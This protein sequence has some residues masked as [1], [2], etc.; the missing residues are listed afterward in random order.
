VILFLRVA[1]IAWAAWDRKY[2]ILTWMVIPYLVEPRSA[3]A[4]SYYAFCVLITLG[5]TGALLNLVLLIKKHLGP[6]DPKSKEEVKNRVG[7]KDANLPH[8]HEMHWMNLTILTLLFYLFLDSL[9][10][11]FPLINT[12]LQKDSLEAMEWAQANTPV[13]SSF[14]ILRGDSGVMV[15][16]VQEWFPAIAQRRSNTTLQGLEWTLNSRF[17][18]RLNELKGL[19]DCEEISCVEDWAELN[20]LHYTHLMLDHTRLSDSFISSIYSDPAYGLIF[21]NDPYTLFETKP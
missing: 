8:W 11:S 12:T 2:F 16:P 21:A 6:T 10:Y 15:D 18:K 13:G 1:G 7:E 3:P 4:V 14:L 20:S 9:L 19:Q 17:P 5:L